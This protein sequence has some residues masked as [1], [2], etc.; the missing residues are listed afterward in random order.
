MA[1]NLDQVSACAACSATVPAS[2]ALPGPHGDMLPIQLDFKLSWEDNEISE[3]LQLVLVKVWDF[4]YQRDLFTIKSISNLPLIP[5]QNLKIHRSSN[6]KSQIT[7]FISFSK[8]LL[9]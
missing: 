4:G 8:A 3:F 1:H 2:Q 7:H 6:S 9:S 5:L